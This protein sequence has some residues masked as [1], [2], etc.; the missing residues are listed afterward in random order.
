MKLL[1]QH[2]MIILEVASLCQWD[3]LEGVRCGGYF[4]QGRLARLVNRIVQFRLA[5]LLSFELQHGVC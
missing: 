5:S 4:M 3:T 2:P 1:F